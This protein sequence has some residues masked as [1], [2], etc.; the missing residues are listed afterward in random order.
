MSLELFRRVKVLEGKVDEL[1]R[2]LSQAAV[3]VHPAP[4]APVPEVKQR[5]QIEKLCPHC[6]AAPAYFFHVRKCGAKK[7]L[8]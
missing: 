4:P 6:N 1:E 5:K 7:V 3:V 2:K 8:G